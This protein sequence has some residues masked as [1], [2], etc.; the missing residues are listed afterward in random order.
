M[1]AAIRHVWPLIP[2]AK[3]VNPR[4]VRFVVIATQVHH[5]AGIDNMAQLFQGAEMLPRMLPA[6]KV[7]TNIWDDGATLEEI[8]QDKSVPA[9]D[10]DNALKAMDDIDA[11]AE[12]IKHILES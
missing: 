12:S 8:S 10:R 9:I 7:F 3:D 1:A 2:G 11:I 5:R 6:R 4:H